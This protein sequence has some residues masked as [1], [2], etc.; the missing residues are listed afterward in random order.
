[1]G[2]NLYKTVFKKDNIRVPLKV[3]IE[4]RKDHRFS[5]AKRSAILRMPIF[6]PQATRQK[7]YQ[8]FLAWIEKHHADNPE[9]FVRFEVKDYRTGDIMEIFGE[10]Y[11][12]EVSVIAGTTVRA[13]MDLDQK[14]INIG[15]PDSLDE[16]DDRGK[17]ISKVIKMVVSKA[18]KPLVEHRLRYLGD[19]LVGVRFN[20][21]R[22]KDSL[23][24]WGSC[25]GK[26]N[27]NIS[28][29]T[30]LLPLD[31][32][33]YVLIHELCHLKELNHSPAFWGL[34]AE[35]LPNYKEAE[36]WISAHGSTLHY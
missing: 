31:K 22:L 18:L 20:N 19:H 35:A 32:I 15:T 36:D 3:H 1:M 33:D 34:V 29:R 5:I 2:S 25:S 8:Q 11:R 17:H 21:F 6:Y 9:M 4:Y 26:N 27:I 23:S 28:I 24:N 12:L 16:S 10:R 13:T 7:T 14:I 30:L